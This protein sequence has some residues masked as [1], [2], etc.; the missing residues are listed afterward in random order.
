MLLVNLLPL[1]PLSRRIHRYLARNLPNKINLQLSE[2]A[3]RPQL[4]SAG[5]VHQ[6]QIKVQQRRQQQ[7][8]LGGEYLVNNHNNLSN[9]SKPLS[10]DLETHLSNHSNRVEV[11]LEAR[12]VTM[13]PNQLVSQRLVVSKTILL[14][15]I[16]DIYN[17]IGGGAPAFGGGA[18]GTQN[19]PQQQ[20]QPQPAGGLFG[21]TQTQPATG[22]NA[23]SMS[24]NSHFNI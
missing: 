6:P 1:V 15:V 19:Q 16:T 10:V 2:A 23:F 24:H 17:K 14:C 18:F 5:L 3:P 21:N 11:Y 12:S 13:R 7:V 8:D 20:Q 9:L 22:F 4:D